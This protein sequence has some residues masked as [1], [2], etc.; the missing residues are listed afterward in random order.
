[1]SA[2]ALAKALARGAVGFVSRLIAQAVSPFDIINRIR[3]AYPGMNMGEVGSTYQ[4]GM[5]SYSAGQ[6][7]TSVGGSGLN[8]LAE[9]PINTFLAP[10]IPPGNRFRFQIIGSFLIPGETEPRYR[11]VNVFSPTNLSLSELQ[12]KWLDWFIEMTGPQGTL[13]ASGGPGAPTPGP[14]LVR[15]VERAF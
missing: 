2:I 8:T 11:T 9:I 1:M 6:E 12:Q 7:L 3:S 5:A 15:D 13:P 10:S 14:I 4:L